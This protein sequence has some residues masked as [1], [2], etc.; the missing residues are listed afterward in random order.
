MEAGISV[1]T[2]TPS[3]ASVAPAAG[4]RAARRS[5]LEAV[6]PFVGLTLL[7]ALWY[8]TWFSGFV[9]QRLLPRPDQVLAVFWT[10]LSTGGLHVDIL[11]SLARV[12]TGVLIGCSAAIP[13]G[14]LLAWY[15]KADRKSTRLNSSHERRSRMPSSA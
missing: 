12:V 10:E 9:S 8:A 11:T 1:D 7:I 13:V 4:L 3:K 14:I 15:P 6:Y 2:L 5:W